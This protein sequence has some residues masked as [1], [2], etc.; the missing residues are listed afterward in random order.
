MQVQIST[1]LHQICEPKQPP[2]LQTSLNSLTEILE[3]SCLLCPILSPSLAV[4]HTPPPKPT[5]HTAELA[6]FCPPHAQ[7]AK[8]NR[9]SWSSSWF[10]TRVR[11]FPSDSLSVSD[12]VTVGVCVRAPC[13][14]NSAI[15]AVLRGVADRI[16]F[17]ILRSRVG[18]RRLNGFCG[19][20]GGE[21]VPVFLST[22][23]TTDQGVC[24]SWDS[25]ERGR[26]E[27]KKKVQSE[28]QCAA[29]RESH[30]LL[31]FDSGPRTLA[32]KRWDRTNTC[33]CVTPRAGGNN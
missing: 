20:S 21:S 1:P 31:Q 24:P 7:K 33:T 14:H 5:V 17:Q 23:G 8:C 10:S 9:P 11:D 6:G 18:S 28:N 15:W 29:G 26:G 12:C 27:R 22:V 3:Y 4:G 19:T 30:T 2:R 16:P 32:A 25:R 13:G